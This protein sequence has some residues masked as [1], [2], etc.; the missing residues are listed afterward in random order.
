MGTKVECGTDRWISNKKFLE[1]GL[2]GI[3]IKNQV[4]IAKATH[5]S[6]IPK[7]LKDI[8]DKVLPLYNKYDLRG[9]ISTEVRVP[10]KGVGYFLEPTARQGFPPVNSAVTMYGNFSKM[11]HACAKNEDIVPDM[12]YK[13]VVEIIM[14]SS[15]AGSDPIPVDYPKEY[16]DNIWLKSPVFVDGQ[17]YVISIDKGNVVGGVSVGDD[18]LEDAIAKCKEIVA[19]VKAP[20]IFYD[21]KAFDEALKQLEEARKL[22]VGF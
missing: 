18:N 9:P 6:N 5:E 15:E 16:E 17:H 4:Y 7:L 8:D 20:G 1:Y 22:E 21:E 19:Q 12:D 14:S 11:C 3:E 2:Q 13:H 10:K